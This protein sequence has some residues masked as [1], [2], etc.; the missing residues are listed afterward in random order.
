MSEVLLFT[1]VAVGLYFTTDWVI[2][3]IESHRGEPLAN[4]SVVFFGIIMVL[5]VISFEV[6]QRLLQGGSLY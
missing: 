3:L 2:R 1:I 6:I 5:A 4:R